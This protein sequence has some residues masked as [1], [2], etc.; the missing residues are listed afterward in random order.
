MEAILFALW[1]FLPAG[2]SNMAPI[3]VARIPR[4][5]NWNTPID[6]HRSWRGHRIF[7]PHKTIRGLLAGTIAGAFVGLIQY[8]LVDE[9]GTIIELPSTLYSGY[10]PIYLGIL[11]GAGA[12]I[13]DALE[14]FF[15]RQSG[16]AAGQSWFPFDQI[17]YII[18]ACL[19][20][21]IIAPLSYAQ[22]ILILVIW[23]SMH[24]GAGYIGYIFRLKSTPI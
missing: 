10:T 2:V 22:Y 1:Y 13:G 12:L 16:V 18:G 15:K 4:L 24:L 20:A 17:D 9:I 14:S 21:A 19:L 7:G 8:L 6:L 5:R 3:F 11:L 23:F